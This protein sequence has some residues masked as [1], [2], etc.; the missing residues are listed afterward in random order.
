M[1]EIILIFLLFSFITWSAWVETLWIA[2]V[3]ILTYLAVSW[4]FADLSHLSFFTSLTNVIAFTICSLGIGALWSLWKWRKWMNS[5]RVQ[6]LLN[7]SFKEFKSQDYHGSFK[8]SVWFPGE[9]KSQNNIER[10]I[11]WIVLWPFSMVVYFFED[12]L[13]DIGRWIYN[14]LGRVYTSITEAAL[15]DEMK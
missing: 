14:R 11:S 8:D 9:A 12:F 5:P 10:I 3:A 4:F 2:M 15:T 13:S 6:K 7:R 1:L